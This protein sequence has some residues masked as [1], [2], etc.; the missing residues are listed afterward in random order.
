M[1]LTVPHMGQLSIAYTEILRDHGVDMRPPP[2][3]S[4]KTLNLGVKHSPEFACL[5]F[6]INLGNMIESLSNGAD[7]VL[8]PGGSGPCRFGYYGVVQEQILRSLGHDFTMTLTDNPDSLSDMVGTISG[9]SDIKTKKQ[10]YAVFY[11]ILMK[12]AAL[13]RMEALY[14][15]YKPREINRNESDNAYRN[16]VRIIEKAISYKGLYTAYREATGLFRDVKVD[17]K[18]KPLKIAILGEIFVVIEP[19][20]NMKVEKRLLEM[21]VEVVRGV[22]L[23]DWLNDRFRFKPF[24][25]NQSKLAKKWAYPYLKYASGG[26]SIESVGKTI[27]F[28][29][30]GIDGIVHIMPFTC[31]PE[32]VAATIMNRISSDMY[33]PVLSLIFD[34]H[35]SEANLQTRLE[36]FVDLLERRKRDW[37]DS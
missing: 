26:E 9:I 32:L 6:K 5:P 3:P 27:K 1:K 11:L 16:A 12:M 2:L 4:M 14:H 28:F 25:R 24:R 10:G 17:K 8:M 18:H 20:A 22:W 23:S 19:F 15:R 36:A 31:M 34:E 21:G 13:D 33:F 7:A 30:E 29:K 37:K 35:V